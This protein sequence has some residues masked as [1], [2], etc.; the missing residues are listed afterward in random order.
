MEIGKIS[1]LSNGIDKFLKVIQGILIAFAAVCVVLAVLVAILGEK[2][3]ADAANLSL[4]AIELKLSGDGMEFVNFAR[5]KP[6]IIA[7]LGLYILA[8]GMGWYFIRILREI[9]APM[10]D[11]RPFESGVSKKIMKL[12]VLTM[13]GGVVS[14]I[15]SSLISYLDATCYNLERIFNFNAVER[16]SFDSDS[17][18]MLFII[19]GLVLMFLSFVFKYGEALQKESD[20]TL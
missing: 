13:I 19:I 15:L 14:E 16:Y 7:E 9:L 11:G 1:S 10:K 8:F 2:M 6:T 18:L 4:G 12:G 3:V 5:L 17:H 20:E